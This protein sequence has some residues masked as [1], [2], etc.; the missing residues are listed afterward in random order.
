MIGNQKVLAVI[1]ARGNSKGIP[2]KNLYPVNGKPLIDYTLDAVL[3][4]IIVDKVIVSTESNEIANHVFEYID[5]RYSGLDIS[6]FVEIHNRPRYLSEDQI[7]SGEVAK[8][9]MGLNTDYDVL[10]LLQP[11]SPLRTTLDIEESLR[12]WNMVGGKVVGVSESRE[13]PYLANFLDGGYL[14]PVIDSKFMFTNRQGVPKTYRI[15]GAVYICNRK[16]ILSQDFYSTLD[17]F[18]YIMPGERSVDID[19]LEDV[20]YMEYLLTR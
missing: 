12:Y 2:K 13:I 16:R 18:G 8:H 20:E 6:Y 11:T 15:N 4:A 7:L 10:I 17:V 3:G 19:T 1:P 14:N 9:V 5:K